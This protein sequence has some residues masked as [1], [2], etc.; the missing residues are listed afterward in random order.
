M[1][2]FVPIYLFAFIYVFML[3]FCDSSLSSVFSLFH[4]H[5]VMLSSILSFY[6]NLFLYLFVDFS[7]FRFYVFYVSSVFLPS[8]FLSWLLFLL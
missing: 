3:S 2:L 5:F 8:F 1:H 7:L 6:I 4:L